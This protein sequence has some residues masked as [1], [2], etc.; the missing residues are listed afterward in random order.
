VLGP[1]WG[2]HLEDVNVA[3]GNLVATAGVQG[4]FYQLENLLH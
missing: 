3:L 4:E 1:L 2:T